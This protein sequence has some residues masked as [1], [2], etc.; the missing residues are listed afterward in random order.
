MDVY[1]YTNAFY[2]EA[3]KVCKYVSCMHMCHTIMIAPSYSVPGELLMKYSVNT[4]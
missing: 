3:F 2:T 4:S 1:I